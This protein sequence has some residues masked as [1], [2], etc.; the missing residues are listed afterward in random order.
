MV[1]LDKIVAWNSYYSLN[2]I[3]KFFSVDRPTDRRTD[4]PTDQQT[5]GPTDQLTNRPTYLPIETPTRSLKSGSQIAQDGLILS[6]LRSYGIV[7][8]K[9]S[10]RFDKKYFGI[11]QGFQLQ[12]PMI[13]YLQ[14]DDNLLTF[15][16]ISY[17]HFLYL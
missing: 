6:N 14:V 10:L 7:E 16:T 12:R 2:E 5:D 9:I 8:I 11:I 3:L 13:Y 4:R 15:W 17:F 1:V